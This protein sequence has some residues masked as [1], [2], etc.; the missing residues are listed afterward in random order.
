MK[1]AFVLIA[2]LLLP[3]SASAQDVPPIDET[4]DPAEQPTQTVEVIVVGTGIASGLFNLTTMA[5]GEPSYVAAGVGIGLGLAALAL[6]TVENPA[7]ETGLFAGGAFAIATGLVAMRHR[8]VLDDR[9]AH[10]RLEPAWHAG[11]P[12]LAL[13]VRW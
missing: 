11:A 1:F 7:H 13:V 9:K 4:A 2:A 12:A 10:A 3:A 8:H 6:T 5:A